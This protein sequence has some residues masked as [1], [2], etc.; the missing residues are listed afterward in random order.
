MHATVSL[1]EFW[2]NVPQRNVELLNRVGP[3][4]DTELDRRASD[5]THEEFALGLMDGPYNFLEECPA[6][7]KV[8]VRRKPRWQSGD[9]RNIDDCS[10]NGINE[11]FESNETY[12]PAGV[13]HH[14]SAIKQW[15]ASLPGVKLHGFVADLWK[16]FRQIGIGL[17]L[18]VVFR[19]HNSGTRR[20]GRL[21]G[22][23][24]GAAAC[25]QGCARLPMAICAL[26]QHHLL[27]PVQ[28]YQ[29]DHHCVELSYSVAQAWTLIKR[30][31]GLLG[32]MLATPGGDKYPLPSQVYRLLG[33]KVDLIASPREIQVLPSRIDSICCELNQILSSKKLGKG[34]AA[35]IF[36]KLS[37][38][39]GQLFGRLGRR[40]LAPFKLCVSTGK[41]V[42]P[43]S[44]LKSNVLLLFWLCVLPRGPFRAV[45]PHSG[46]PFVITMSDGEG[47]G[48]VAA[49][50][51]SPAAPGGVHQPC[52]FQLD[53]PPAALHAWS[54]GKE[55]EPQRHI[56]KI[57]AIVLA[58]CLCTWS[59]LIRGSL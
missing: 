11:I 56:N 15:E 31:Y 38:S 26:L 10:V 44:Q 20:F 51:W 47:T 17:N 43:T 27:V 14:V 24:F 30:F 32:P 9:V 49:A 23:P 34:H 2:S 28:H 53:L 18:V 21:R 52:W 55:L 7:D 39:A 1:S 12:K 5:K 19:C 41:M 33:T 48:S 8:L 59:H 13:D 25:V 35:E 46:T 40:H 45:L 57:E 36:G 4:S 29:D 54:E 22:C 16:H 37:F 50:I 3:T 58:I 42:A 6:Q